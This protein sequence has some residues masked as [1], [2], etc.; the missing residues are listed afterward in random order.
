MLKDSHF[1]LNALLFY[2]FQKFKPLSLII[3]CCALW[4]CGA[5][6][7]SK[8]AII[9]FNYLDD[10][11]IPENLYF[12]N[13]EIGGLSGI[14]F[15]GENY[16]VVCDNSSKPRF[17]QI[18]IETHQEKIDTIIFD[19]LIQLQHKSDFIKNNIF[20][21]ESILF[22]AEKNQ[23]VLSS[24]GSI[25]NKKNPSII[26]VDAEG[27][28]LSHYPLPSY[29]KVEGKQQPRSNRVFESLSH[30]IH[31]KG[32]WTATEFPLTEDGPKPKLYRTKSPVRFTFF[33]EKQEAEFQFSYLL[34]PIQKIPY[35]PFS[36]NGV[37]DILEIAP[38][39]FLV[40]ERAFSAG[41]GN[42][43]Y[44][45]LLFLADAS[46]AT[47]TLEVEH[48]KGKMKKEIRPAEKKLV[49]NFK[50][51]RKK[52]QGKRIDNLEGI[53]F[54]PKLPNGNSTIFVISDNNFN[55]FAPH[56]NQVIWLEMVWK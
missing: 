55:S 4:S 31:K 28:Y 34:A 44:S 38:K 53:C 32:I 15:D 48:L 37:T 10:Y 7:A 21:L 42:R 47:N 2:C 46:K 24:E 29:F 52:L 22:N 56:L 9:Q 23:F 25:K 11:I 30:A 36:I 17:Y 14:D 27:N 35:L 50:Q 1:S 5:G 13:T 33:N 40:L 8:S 16:Y 45:G 26:T 49:F 12:E 6:K 19:K 3:L 43:T 41:R 20:D 54:G 39:Q 51:I 18:Q